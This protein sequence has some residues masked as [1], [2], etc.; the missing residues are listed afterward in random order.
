[1]ATSFNMMRSVSAPAAAN[2]DVATPPP[3][4][5]ALALEST[6]FRASTTRRDLSTA[7]RAFKQAWSALERVEVLGQSCRT[8]GARAATVLTAVRDSLEQV[9]L[10][11]CAQNRG[12]V[13][14]EKSYEFQHQHQNQRG[15]VDRDSAAVGPGGTTVFKIQSVM[16]DVQAFATDH[17]AKSTSA[18]LALLVDDLAATT[19]ALSKLTDSL[20]AS[21]ATYAVVVDA[22]AWAHEDAADLARDHLALPRSFQLS[23]SLRGSVFDRFLRERRTDEVPGANETPGQRRAAFVAWCLD[24][25]PVLR[26]PPRGASVVGPRPVPPRATTN[27]VTSSIGLGLPSALAATAGGSVSMRRAATQP[28]SH[29]GHSVSTTPTTQTALARSTRAPSSSL[30]PQSPAAPSARFEGTSTAAAE[31][32]PP[33]SGSS[34]PSTTVTTESRD[35]DAAAAPWRAIEELDPVPPRAHPRSTDDARASDPPVASVRPRQPEPLVVGSAASAKP[36][37]LDPSVETRSH[38]L[39]RSTSTE[40]SSVAMS[41]SS[42]MGSTL[43]EPVLPAIAPRRPDVIVHGGEFEEPAGPEGSEEV[44]TGTG[45]AEDEEGRTQRGDDK[46]LAA[47]SHPGEDERIMLEPSQVTQQDVA[48]VASVELERSIL[49]L[50]LGTPLPLSPL[51][52]DHHPRPRPSSNDPEET[53]RPVPFGL[54]DSLPIDSAPAATSTDNSARLEPFPAPRTPKLPPSPSLVVTSFDDDDESQQ[55]GPP[56]PPARLDRPF[57]IL[58]L[59][60]GGLVGP[61]PQLLA[62]EEYLGTLDDGGASPSRHF[63]LVVGTSSSALPALLVG[64]L[65]LSIDQAL[66][67][68]TD[69]ARSAFAIDRPPVDPSRAELPRRRV[70]GIWSRFFTRQPRTPPAA[71][72]PRP[73]RTD[74]LEAALKRLVPSAATAPVAARSRT[75]CRAAVLAFSRPQQPGQRAEEHWL[76]PDDSESQHLSLVDLVDAAMAASSSPPSSSSTRGSRWVAAPT[77]LNPTRSAIAYAR[78]SPSLLGLADAQRRPIKVVSVSIGYDLATIPTA[79]TTTKKKKDRLKTQS[80][81]EGLIRVKAVGAGN[82][83]AHAALVRRPDADAGGVVDVMRLLEPAGLDARALVDRDEA[84]LVAH[85][86]AQLSERRRRAGPRPPFVDPPASPSSP[87]LASSARR[88]F[89]AAAG[90]APDSPSSFKSQPP[91]SR[92]PPRGAPRDD[93]DDDALLSSSSSSLSLMSQGLGLWSSTRRA[94]STTDLVVGSSRA[95]FFSTTPPS[96][97]RRRADDGEEEVL[98]VVGFGGGGDRSPLPSAVGGGRGGDKLRS[99]ASLGDFGTCAR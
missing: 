82:A 96:S 48:V 90:A 61:I 27:E 65:G 73:S 77:S 63:D 97:P 74:A 32:E 53:T 30:A 22:S 46:D 18:R 69:V 14:L 59:D 78:S 68:C 7:Y 95:D 88:L 84:D 29:L 28:L 67:I 47:P 25:N 93:H 49:G 26:P 94:A 6:A 43:F 23:I 54:L 13:V 38:S 35:P 79:T 91:S 60:G 51:L 17:L 55:E 15:N 87:A 44:E 86:R 8:L 56:S 1:M 21:I 64:Q 83:A 9:E 5:V 99:S 85:W 72:A 57:R 62:V 66:A 52:D 98:N 37:D 39:D 16:L 45:L 33:T 24:A 92:S 81:L 4:G 2:A 40:S 71:L 89:A 75:G 41:T 10:A 34:P 50:A 58:S 11:E 42:S 80:R 31:E 19:T 70:G 3:P 20:R 76:S 36:V 12:R